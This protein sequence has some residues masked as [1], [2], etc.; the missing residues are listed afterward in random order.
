MTTSSSSQ[1]NH[2]TETAP[3]G[4]YIRWQVLLVLAGF[5]LLTTL[6]GYSAYSVTTVLVAERGGV[7]RE[8]VAGNPQYLNPLLC[9]AHEIDR[10]ICPLLFRGLT[11][12]N[13][14]GEIVPDL[15]ESW[16]VTP[17]GLV[18]T[19]RLTANELWQDGQPI[20]ADDVLFTVA[21]LQDPAFPGDPGLADLARTVRVE[22]IDNLTIRFTL[23][24]P[25]TPFQDFTTIGLLP[26]H[27]WEN[28]PAANLVNNPL[29]LTPIGNGS[30]RVAEISADRIRLEPSPFYGRSTPYISALEFRFYPDYPSIF[31]AY[32]AGEVDGIRQI[33]PQNLPVARDRD[34][35]Q[36]FTAVQAGYT[37]VALN[38]QNPDLPF[39]N[40]LA[41]RRALLYSMDRNAMV[42]QDDFGQG[43][44][45]HSPVALEN[46]A[47]QADVRHYDYD[48]DQARKLL[49]QAGW[50]DSDG[51]G[52]RDKNG[53]L[54]SFILLTNDDPIHQALIRR[55]AT[56][57][58]AVGVQAVPQ[59]VSFA[60]LV[61]D[62]LAPR[63]FDAVLLSWADLVGDPDPF[64]LWHSSQSVEG[65]QNYS[66]WA[67]QRADAL[68]EL[69]RR[70]V[71]V[72][73]R[74]RIYGEFQSIFAEDVPALLLYYPVYTYGVSTRVKN[75]QIGPLNRPADR[76]FTF[77]DW[78]IVTRRAPSNQVPTNVPPAPPAG[79][80][81]G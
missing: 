75:V 81:G 50:V 40:E 1:S 73:E 9:D 43:V 23:D 14:H 3:L 56:D 37:M 5:L 11:R 70:V 15:A 33:L 52:I 16:T 77:A 63:R 65:R 4:R 20:T 41:V 59:I 58:R 36:L 12:I 47:Y 67:N 60:G 68:M 61:G 32:A 72:A 6:L 19:F 8:G 66:G 2:P 49:D 53:R 10:D 48:P 80:A 57:W 17:D 38:L 74:K 78:Y 51:D 55:M 46:W 34:D 25:F 27:I 79:G 18:H 64:P 69:G 31:A 54:L 26:R 35:L 13:D 42:Q 62:F 21:M 71:D 22:L 24:R 44:V 39:F 76:F 29:N 7:F 45:A 30:M 28:V